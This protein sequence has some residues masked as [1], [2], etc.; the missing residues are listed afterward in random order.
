[1][2]DMRSGYIS[3]L[4]VPTR[5]CVKNVHCPVVGEVFMPMVSSYAIMEMEPMMAV[6]S[7]R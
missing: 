3:L 7:M 6:S 2:H 1:M 4:P 5:A